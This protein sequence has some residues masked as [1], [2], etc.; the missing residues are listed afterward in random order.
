MLYEGGIRSPLIAWGP[1]LLDTNTR[2]VTN[3]TAV[4]CSLDIVR[5]LVTICRAKLPESELDGEDLSETLLGHAS[6]GRS[7]P[8]FWRRPPDRPGRT[9]R[10]GRTWQYAT[11]SGN[12]WRSTMAAICSCTTC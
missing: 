2:G 5:S 6:A 10:P 4:L 7:R 8:I 9:A 12:C 3:D 1:G 11:A